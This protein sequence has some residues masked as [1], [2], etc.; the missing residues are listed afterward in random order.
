MLCCCASSSSEYDEVRS[1]AAAPVGVSTAQTRPKKAAKRQIMI[2]RYCVSPEVAV[3][4]KEAAPTSLQY[5]EASPQGTLS[6]MEETATSGNHLGSRR[7]DGTENEQ[8]LF[9][10]VALG[11]NVSDLTMSPNRSGDAA[12]KVAF[13]PFEDSNVV[14]YF[15][16]DNDVVRPIQRPETDKPEPKLSTPTKNKNKIENDGGSPQRQEQQ[17]QQQQRQRPATD[18]PDEAIVV[19]PSLERRHRRSEL[20]TSSSNATQESSQ[21]PP[22]PTTPPPPLQEKH[23]TTSSSSSSTTSATE[24]IPDRGTSILDLEENRDEKLTVTTMNLTNFAADLNSVMRNVR[25]PADKSSPSLPEDYENNLAYD[26]WNTHNE[27][28]SIRQ[29][30]NHTF[31]E[32]SPDRN[33]LVR[34]HRRESGEVEK[35]HIPLSS[36]STSGS[37]ADSAATPLAPTQQPTRF[38]GVAA[39]MYLNRH[40][41]HHHHHH[42]PSPTTTTNGLVIHEPLKPRAVPARSTSDHHKDNHPSV[43]LR[44]T[45]SMDSTEDN[46]NNNKSPR[47]GCALGLNELKMVAAPQC[48]TPTR[49]SPSSA[50]VVTHKNS[51][52]NDYIAAAIS[53]SQLPDPKLIRT[54]ISEDPSSPPQTT[55]APYSV[56]ENDGNNM[57]LGFF[58][59][60]LSQAGGPRLRKSD[61]A[62]VGGQ[63]NHSNRIPGSSFG[64]TLSNAR[65]L[66]RLNVDFVL[67]QQAQDVSFV[68]SDV[69]SDRPSDNAVV[70]SV[71]T[72]AAKYNNENPSLANIPAPTTPSNLLNE[73]ESEKANRSDDALSD[74]PSDVD[75]DVRQRYLMACRLLKVALIKEKHRL[76]M[77][78]LSF[79]Q[80]LMSTEDEDHVPSEAD[81]EV[82]Q[83]AY[84]SLQQN[85]SQHAVS[86]QFAESVDPMETRKSKTQP[87]FSDRNSAVDD[88][89]SDFLVSEFGV[90]EEQWQGD[91]HSTGEISAILPVTGENEGDSYGSVISLSKRLQPPRCIPLHQTAKDEPHLIL[92]KYCTDPGVLTAPIMEG[93]RQCLPKA[94][95]DQNF[96]LK[97][98]TDQESGTL[99]QLLPKIRHSVYTIIGV[100]TTKGDVFGAF[101]ASPWRNNSEWFGSTEAF[102]WKLKKSRNEGAKRKFNF[103]NELQIFSYVGSDDDKHIQYCTEKTLAVGGGDWN[104]TYVATEEEDV[105]IGFTLDGDLMG[106]ETSSC[107][108]FGNSKL[109]GNG[110]TEFEVSTLEVWTLT[111]Y[112]TLEESVELEHSTS[113]LLQ[114]NDT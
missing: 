3:D 95:A 101:C 40:H 94:V 91:G 28:S 49:T 98:S 7:E 56:T 74:F 83:S 34:R 38:G 63:S 75:S 21:P 84:A 26:E 5:L 65:N 47:R 22:P 9:K 29:A 27:T 112:D 100:E 69:F 1:K 72:S 113:A 11:R 41:H 86:V 107:S 106:G 43:S 93:I 15:E 46:A 16:M 62:A 67:Q 24:T 30:T 12:F 36:E 81:V 35:A 66:K 99:S 82:L 32:S 55:R 85:Q 110:S 10:I 97:F 102:L 44:E 17:Q 51:S 45:K 104:G 33:D 2:D 20:T 103:D 90:D 64:S 18:D 71:G 79:L 108:T 14:T 61:T 60:N 96:W 31:N 88:T 52:K 92:G 25:T 68:G 76:P 114:S 37:L 48:H 105:G 53:A 8:G 70:S 111:P 57:A 59:D 19:I 89:S 87:S 4:Q 42:P 80:G 77:S 23:E 54:T 109:C 6:T 73:F 78:E 39:C 50:P 13:S 58:D